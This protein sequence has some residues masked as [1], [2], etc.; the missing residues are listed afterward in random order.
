MHNHIHVC[1]SIKYLYI[2]PLDFYAFYVIKYIFL[3]YYILYFTS[4]TTY[5]N[6]FNT[7]YKTKVK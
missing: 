7:N 2:R 4:F 1:I 6:F 3:T 5:D